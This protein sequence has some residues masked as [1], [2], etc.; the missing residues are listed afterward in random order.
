MLEALKF[1]RPELKPLIVLYVAGCTGIDEL[2]AKT[3]LSLPAL[4][5][6]LAVYQALGLV[7]RERRGRYK[8]TGAGRKHVEQVLSQLRQL[9]DTVLQ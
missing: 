8:I 9:A 5:K 6:H 4:Y 3:G 1:L 7:A 2:R